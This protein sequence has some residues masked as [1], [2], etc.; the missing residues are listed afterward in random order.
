MDFTG[1]TDY[2]FNYLAKSVTGKKS[3]SEL[4]LSKTLVSKNGQTIP[5]KFI[6]V[7]DYFY[8]HRRLNF[9]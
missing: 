5:I 4:V 6:S 3:L 1:V 9:T 2:E 7:L 8:L